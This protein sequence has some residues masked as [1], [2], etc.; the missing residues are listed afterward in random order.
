M[1]N[2]GNANPTYKTCS[3]RCHRKLRATTEN[4]A[5]DLHRDCGLSNECKLC[6]RERGR[7]ARRDTRSLV[8][9]YIVDGA[10]LQRA[11]YDERVIDGQRVI[12]RE[13]Y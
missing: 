13:I 3:G 5:R 7:T 9:G 8:R 1:A 6:K 10:P 12:V 2:N 4:F 11:H